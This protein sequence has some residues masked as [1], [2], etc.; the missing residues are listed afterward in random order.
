MRPATCSRR[1]AGPKRCGCATTPLPADERRP[2]RLSFVESISILDAQPRRFG[3][4]QTIVFYNDSD[5]FHYEKP[6]DL[7]DLRSG[8]VCSPNNFAYA[9][10]LQE[11]M[12][13]ISALANYDRWAALDEEA[14]R[15]AKLRWY[16]RM[17]AVGRA[18]R[19]RLPRPR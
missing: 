8:M 4:D 18:V 13:R 9:E 14:Y 2:G 19:A 12:M 5:K 3:Y 10:P 16:D 1:P 6:D 15:L 7:V 11:G 17:A